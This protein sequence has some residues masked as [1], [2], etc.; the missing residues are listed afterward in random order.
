MRRKPIRLPAGYYLGKQIYFV[1]ICT[2]ERTTV[3]RS[4][5]C[6]KTASEI[7]EEACAEE[8]FGLYA[9]CFMPD[10]VHLELVGI[11]GSAH[12]SS[13]IRTFKGRTA[14]ALRTLKVRNLWQK[15]FFEHILRPGESPDA[16]AW[17]ILNNPVRA[18]LIE[19]WRRWPFSG[20]S[21]LEWAEMEEPAEYYTPPWKMRKM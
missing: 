19:N 20:S 6:A 5:E 17:Y 13:F 14:A 9:F 21:V 12:L 3:F 2:A 11:N 4:S 15:G 8:S 1:T 18:N 7:L 10:H 16:V